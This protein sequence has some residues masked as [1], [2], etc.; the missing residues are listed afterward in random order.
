MA[1]TKKKGLAHLSVWLNH[2]RV[3]T[4]TE[5]PNDQNIFA[6]DPA[7]IAD[8]HRPVLSLSFYNA[9]GFLDPEPQRTGM[10]VAPFFSNLLPEGELRHYVAQRSGTKEARDLPLL[11]LL[12]DD[13]P[14]AVIVRREQDGPPPASDFSAEGLFK[15]ETLQQEQPLRFSL[16]GVQMKFSAVGSPERGLTVPVEGKG[17][18]WV[19]KLPS[20]QYPLVPENEYSMM[21]FA[22]AIGITVAENGLVSAAEVEGLPDFMRTQA[23]ALWV[24]R[25][26]RAAD[27][28]RIHIEDFNQVYRQFPESKYRNYSY[29]NIATDLSRIA[30]DSIAE[31][32]RRLVFSAAIGNA[33]M[34]LKNWS[35]IY[36][37]GRTPELSP[38]YDFVSTIAY[39][40]DTTMSLSVAREKDVSK[41]DREL[42]NRFI[43]KIPAP[44]Q[45]LRDAALHTA[46]SIVH[47]WPSFQK[48]IPMAEEAKSKLTERMAL[49]P[50][51]K[52]F[53]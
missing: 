50:L 10:R 38:A 24:K 28:S 26:D 14:G 39:M 37:D 46:E 48:D 30:A 53:H 13:L 2:A 40:P 32:M 25:F 51:T 9:E 33:D 11:E 31:F 17:G 16:A 8:E 18:H 7:Y 12:G 45:L 5:I 36:R 42:L 19:L 44:P 20:R 41:F 4:I 1:M 23:N 3:G 49:F 27:G 29:G 47:L 6:F 52:M 21:Q 35:L 34:H 43:A 15:A 22:R